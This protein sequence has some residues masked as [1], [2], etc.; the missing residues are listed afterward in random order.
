[1]VESQL[2][3][4]FVKV[5]KQKDDQLQKQNQKII[6]YTTALERQEDE[7]KELQRQINALRSGVQNATQVVTMDDVKRLEQLIKT[8]TDTTKYEKTIQ[9]HQQTI[10]ELRKTNEELRTE[11][12][13][14][15]AILQQ[16]ANKFARDR[17]MLN[18]QI[19]KLR[20]RISR[21]EEAN[22][23]ATDLSEKYTELKRKYDE[24]EQKHNSLMLEIQT[25]SL[26]LHELD[27]K[28]KA[29]EDKTAN[30]YVK[31]TEV[32]KNLMQVKEEYEKILSKKSMIRSSLDNI[33]QKI[34][35][36]GISDLMEDF[37]SL[38]KIVND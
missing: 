1:M 26:R 36:A 30:E 25:Q 28:N 16:E 3:D 9:E 23:D 27:E 31:Y 29:L 4:D 14:K 24:D 37:V 17:S 13:K 32:N 38:N 11:L 19:E 12:E 8:G 7:K 2:L 6:A 15:D 35:S 5:Y 22:D 33:R 18:R 20:L 21:L 34:E 10:Q